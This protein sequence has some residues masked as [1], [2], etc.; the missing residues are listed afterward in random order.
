MGLV[1]LDFGSSHTNLGHERLDYP[2][3]F[4]FFVVKGRIDLMRF[5]FDH[6]SRS[7]PLDFLFFWLF[8][9]L[10]L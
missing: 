3:Y 6:D 8:F 9:I 7:D 2:D 1:Y 5:D 10:L 4:A